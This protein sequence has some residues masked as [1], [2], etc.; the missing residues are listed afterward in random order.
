MENYAEYVGLDPERGSLRMIGLQ[1]GGND[2]DARTVE[3]KCHE[4]LREIGLRNVPHPKRDGVVLNDLF[5]LNG[6][7]YP[8]I[9][10]LIISYAERTGNRLWSERIEPWLIELDERREQERE[11]R[12]IEFITEGVGGC[13][14]TGS[15]APTTLAI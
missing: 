14:G 2:T 8:T 11:Q 4:L 1:W 6:Y 3:R 9:A 15:T 13:M 5:C 10:E 7:T 12:R